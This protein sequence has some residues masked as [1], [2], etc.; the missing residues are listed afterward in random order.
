MLAQ[1]IVHYHPAHNGSVI[2]SNP[3]WALSSSTCRE[4]NTPVHTP[5]WWVVCRLAKP[6]PPPPVAT[7]PLSR[8]HNPPL[9]Q[10]RLKLPSRQNQRLARHPRKEPTGDR[11]P[12]FTGTYTPRVT[13]VPNMFK[14]EY[15]NQQMVLLGSR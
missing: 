10:K 4:D 9:L 5:L 2:A 1:F 8:C 11:R 3:S 12:Y 15:S 14:S 7:N 13:S 6:T